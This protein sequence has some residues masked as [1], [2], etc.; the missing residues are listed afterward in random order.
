MSQ[1]E[2]IELK[3]ELEF[4]RRQ[5]I[6]LEGELKEKDNQI[7][8]LD[9][10]LRKYENEIRQ[11]HTTTANIETI[12]HERVEKSTELEREKMRKAVE[13]LT[14]KNVKLENELKTLYNDSLT[15]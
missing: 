4:R 14:A 12:I 7:I 9:H 10:T 11:A 5:I 8:D 15:I 2:L 3:K 13:E 6:Q 1:K